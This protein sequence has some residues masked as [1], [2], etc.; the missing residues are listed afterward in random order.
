MEISEFKIAPSL[1]MLCVQAGFGQTVELWDPS[2]DLDPPSGLLRGYSI[3]YPN[4][5]CD[6]VLEVCTQ[7]RLVLRFL[8]FP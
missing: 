6:F 4:S 1:A 7:S 2:G 3:L 5:P 8:L